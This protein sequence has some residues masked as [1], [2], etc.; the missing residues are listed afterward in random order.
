MLLLKA[1]EFG[2]LLGGGLAGQFSGH[3]DPYP[4]AF[5]HVRWCFFIRRRRSRRRYEYSL[6]FNKRF[7]LDE[8]GV[9]ASAGDGM[10]VAVFAIGDPA[11]VALGYG[12][13]GLTGLFG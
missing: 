10:L 11:V 12:E 1:F 6:F 5:L 3:Q 4:G 2:D 13:E 9:P 7:D 8:D